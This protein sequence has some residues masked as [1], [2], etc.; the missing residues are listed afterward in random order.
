ME[1][2]HR[3]AAK[4]P[5]LDSNINVATLMLA[6]EGRPLKQ[7]GRSLGYRMVLAVSNSG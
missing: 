6:V 2:L 4:C 3:E 5:K 1:W 7:L